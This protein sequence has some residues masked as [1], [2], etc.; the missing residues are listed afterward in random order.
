MMLEPSIDSLMEKV[1]SKYA[2]V[3][4]SAKRAR[5]MQDSKKSLMENPKSYKYVGKALEEIHAEKI[6]IAEE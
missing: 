6:Q 4:L 2:L 5:E 3:I 1:P